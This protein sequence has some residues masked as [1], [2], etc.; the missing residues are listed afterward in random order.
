LDR[1]SLLQLN[2]GLDC[3]QP[4]AQGTTV[5]VQAAAGELW[6][7]HTTP[8]GDSPATFAYRFLLD[9][10]RQQCGVICFCEQLA[11]P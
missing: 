4:L 5:C 1:A 7:Q 8:Y 6:P 10:T 11:V 3:S 9:A 2:P